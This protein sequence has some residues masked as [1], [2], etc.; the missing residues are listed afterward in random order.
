MLADGHVLSKCFACGIA[1]PIRTKDGRIVKDPNLSNPRADS[2]SLYMN[3]VGD[4]I[5]RNI[6][7]K[8]KVIKNTVHKMLPIN[9]ESALAMTDQTL[10][11]KR[12]PFITKGRTGNHQGHLLGRDNEGMSRHKSVI[13]RDPHLKTFSK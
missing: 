2:F 8:Q 9:R 13:V 7:P 6:L 3:Y 5:L 10:L 4:M 1:Y 12:V 11:S